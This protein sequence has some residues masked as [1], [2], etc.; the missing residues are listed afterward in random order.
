[1]IQKPWSLKLI[2]S[3]PIPQKVAQTMKE[4]LNGTFGK[5]FLSS[6]SHCVLGEPGPS[7]EGSGGL[8]NLGVIGVFP[9]CHPSDP[10]LS[11]RKSWRS[12]FKLHLG[13]D[14]FSPLWSN[15][16]TVTWA[17]LAKAASPSPQSSPSPPSS[18]TC[19][20]GQLEEKA[21]SLPPTRPLL[22]WRAHL[23]ALSPASPGPCPIQAAPPH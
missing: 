15:L 23:P 20:P 9:V 6:L 13:S 12:L 8:P 7:C 11:T 19:S 5:F 14:Q 16:P 18:L 21:R 22:S 4:A 2:P 1:M 17:L 3:P 10:V